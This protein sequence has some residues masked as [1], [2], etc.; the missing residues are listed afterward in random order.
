M[1]TAN[2]LSPSL[3]NPPAIFSVMPFW[4]W[5]DDLDEAEIIRQIG[6]F[7][8]HGV[9][10]FVIH[11]RV[12]LPRSLGWMSDRLL[13]FYQLA[14]DEARRLGM[15]V[16]LYDE[17]MYPS[18]S[19]S[20]QVV[21]ANPSHQCRCLDQRPLATGETPLPGADEC[22]VAVVQRRNGQRIAVIDRK[23]D[24]FIRG[25]HYISDGP[26]EDEPPAGDILN[27]EAVA[28]FI[29]LVYDCFAGR[30]SA[31][32]GKTILGIFTDEPSLLGRPRERGVTPGTTGILAELERILGYDLTPHLAALWYDDEPDAQ[33]IRDDFQRGLSLRLEET[34][35]AQL[36]RWCDD[37]GL[38]L[39]GHPVSG[40][41]IGPLRFFHIPGQDLVWRWVLPDHPTSLEGPES[42]Q[43][44]CSASAMLHGGR[45]RNANECYGAYGHGFTWQEMLWLA[46]WCFVRGV[47]LL[48]PHAFYYSLRG[49]RRDERPPDVGPHAVWWP[50]YPR[51]ADACRRL[52]WLNADS[53]HICHIAILGKAHRLPWRAAKVCFQRQRDFN[54]LEER[55]LWEGAVVDEDG[56]HLAGMTYRALI[57]EEA[58][59][60]RAAPAI[61]RLEQAGR[62]IHWQPHFPEGELIARLDALAPVDIRVAEATPGL[63]VRH[64]LKEGV[65]YFFLFAEENRPM[66][67]TVILPATG[68]TLCYDPWRNDAAPFP[69]DGRMLLGGHELRVIAMSQWSEATSLVTLQA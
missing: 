10:G 52:S 50:D 34:Y 35:Y 49:P 55:H 5:N 37:H 9:F 67:I 58:P 45:R 23:A 26:A 19:S 62:V 59:D 22:L 53:Q 29:H 8:D 12:G 61:Q 48:Y 68:V 51:Y 65:H 46:N 6:D 47:N 39:T 3:L 16:I 33:R 15:Y 40:D 18:G 21:A 31:H 42:T 32:F 54:Y 56:V 7:A 36:S 69:A 24:S 60:Q 43:A 28:S 27:P 14:I 11:P 57:L 30:F 1:T 63:R 41:V 44:K 4:F 25:L 2:S 64:V 13:D 20:G 17:G 38:A 66:E